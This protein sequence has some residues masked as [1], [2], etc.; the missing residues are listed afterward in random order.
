[1]HLFGGCC[2]FLWK[3]TSAIRD[4]AKLAGVAQKQAGGRA[5]K[6]V[7]TMLLHHKTTTT[8]TNKQ[9]G[10][11]ARQA[12]G[13]SGASKQTCDCARA[14]NCRR[15]LLEH[16]N[17]QKTKQTKKSSADTKTIVVE[18]QEGTQTDIPRAVLRAEPKSFAAAGA[19][20]KVLCCLCARVCVE[21]GARACP[22]PSKQPPR[23]GLIDRALAQS[24]QKE[25]GQRG[26]PS[27][28]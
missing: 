25:V 13:S 18:K 7:K 14:P 22:P 17:N 4:Q 6:K 23:H 16:T 20:G 11:K 3:Q 28:G 9:G 15:P 5:I 10:G 2:D 27:G 12:R 24:V 19:R 21:G 26:N 1:V 8:K